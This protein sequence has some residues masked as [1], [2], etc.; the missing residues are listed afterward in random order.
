MTTE[1]NKTQ[2]ENNKGNLKHD[3]KSNKYIDIIKEEVETISTVIPVKVANRLRDMSIEEDRTVSKIVKR[4]LVQSLEA[5]DSKKYAVRGMSQE[6][7]DK[8][9][10]VLEKDRK[11]FAKKHNLKI[12]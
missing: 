3:I 11:A 8:I 7:L 9:V 4:L 12:Q 5:I 1:E 6:E 10:A 2:K